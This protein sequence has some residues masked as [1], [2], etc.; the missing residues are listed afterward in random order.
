MGFCT[1][2]GRQRSGTTQFCTGCGTRFSDAP[3][4]TAQAEPAAGP[5]PAPETT[6]QPAPAPET[7]IQQAPAA[8]TTFEPA[9]HAQDTPNW[10]ADQAPAPAADWVPPASVD[11]G[12]VPAAGTD[13][14]QAAPGPGETRA[15]MR[16]S[17]G[18]QPAPGPGESHADTWLDISSQRPAGPAPDAGGADSWSA[19]G[20]ESGQAEPSDPGMTRWDTNWYRPSP[21]S[22]PPSRPAEPAQPAPTAPAPQPGS[23][24][25][26]PP[27][28]GQGGSGQGGSGQGGYGQGAP[29]KASYGPASY[30]QGP[31]GQQPYPA[32]P[33]V[34]GT[35]GGKPVRRA[36]TAILSVI[37][38]VVV[39]AVG[40]GA[41]AAVTLLTGKHGT[42]STRGGSTPTAAP[43][44]SA[45]SA[46]SPA[47]SASS[48]SA[49][50]SPTES[51]T[52]S[53]TA[54]STGV[55]V[56]SGLAA[57]LAEPAVA[58]FLNRYF[59]AINHH[60]YNAYLA[61]LGPVLRNKETRAS[62]DS[63]Y[64]STT[65]FAETLTGIAPTGDGG[66]AATVT[67][68]S[69]QNPADSIT[70]TACTHWTITLYLQPNGSS[71][72][73]G[74]APTDYHASYQAC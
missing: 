67:F 39:L 3:D 66:Q 72:L 52:A 29:G 18:N 24:G 45:T 61:L 22:Q 9:Q 20:G 16:T 38:V 32:V 58:T 37:I 42:T 1:K 11:W 13:Q 7:V 28:Y 48:S 31:Y 59:T 30:E 56:A 2:C 49:P 68:T 19:F 25:Y 69:K 12:A 34:A 26:G 21:G 23:A 51:A 62:F 55:A 44:T 10:A 17:I 54:S 15:D 27:S 73:D 74:P 63:G 35:V 14:P 65:D 43:A 41:Y 40:G 64:G 36:Q 57:N 46:T 4:A 53:P 60:D 50:S 33:H 47:R 70:K 71:Y 8:G 6:R 5:P